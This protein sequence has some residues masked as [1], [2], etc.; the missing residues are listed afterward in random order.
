MLFVFANLRDDEIFVYTGLI[1]FRRT[2]KN[3]QA[4]NLLNEFIYYIRRY[5]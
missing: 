1:R 2:L 4:V 5:L 3:T